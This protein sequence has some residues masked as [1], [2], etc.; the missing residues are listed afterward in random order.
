MVYGLVAEKVW[1]SADR[2][3]YTFFLRK[4]A[5]FHDGSPLTAHD[6]AFSLNTIKAE[7]SPVYSQMLR[8]LESA[9]AAADDVLV[10]KVAPNRPR[11]LPL[12][13]A[14]MPIFSKAYYAKHK[15]NET[16][17]EP[18]L[19]SSAYKIGSLEPGRFISFVRVPDYWA[20]DLPV[21]VGQS[22][23][24]VIRYEYYGDLMSPSRRSSR[25]RS[26]CMRR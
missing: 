12:A 23:F 15:F 19:G 5:R 18:P 11:N 16:T 7:G 25:G 2:L 14:G 26:P 1:I 22:N 6:A 20:K 3:T 21:N 4:E 10:V 8:E 9:T 13:V 17:L 24:D